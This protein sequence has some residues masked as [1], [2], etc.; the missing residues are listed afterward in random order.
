MLVDMSIA[1]NRRIGV[2][3]N[4]VSTG[5]AERPYGKDPCYNLSVHAIPAN[6]LAGFFCLRPT[7]GSFLLVPDAALSSGSGRLLVG[8]P[9][10][11]R[12]LGKAQSIHNS[13][14][15]LSS[16]GCALRTPISL[17]APGNRRWN[18]LRP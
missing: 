13:G 12:S 7:R 2:L 9:R 1:T 8:D 11:T 14:A 5:S 6:T 16:P 15:T 17:S 3:S 18:L 10:C 4:V